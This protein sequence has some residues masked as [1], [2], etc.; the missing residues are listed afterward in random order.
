MVEILM[1][2]PKLVTLGLFKVNIF[3]NERYDV[4]IYVHDITKKCY[5]M[6]QTIF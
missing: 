6:P 1:L 4:K 3:C 5:D 2:S